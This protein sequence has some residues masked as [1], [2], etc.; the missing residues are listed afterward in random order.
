MRKIFAATSSIFASHI[1]TQHHV[2]NFQQQQADFTDIIFC[3]GAQN[4][5]FFRA[6]NKT[7]QRQISAGKLPGTQGL[8]PVRG[9]GDAIN[10]RL[11][12]NYFKMH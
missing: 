6:M 12:P 1:F 10:H 9:F 4:L 7:F 3:R 2:I 11:L 5:M 8:K